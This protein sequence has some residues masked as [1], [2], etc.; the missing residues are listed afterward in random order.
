MQDRTLAACYGFNMHYRF[1]SPLGPIAY[2]WNGRFCSG[3]SLGD[4]AA[5]ADAG[6]DPVSRWL[7]VYFT[8]QAAPLP[9]LAPPATP[10]QLKMRAGLLAIPFGE[11]CTY[12][13]LAARLGTAP[14]A[15]GQA[16]GANPLP[17]LIPCHRVLAV[18]GPGGFASGLEWKERLIGFEHDFS[19]HP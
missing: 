13:Q 16:L 18:N 14:R 3:L 6:N 9:L 17:I 7:V 8:G 2:D 19:T 1:N 15:L 10:F 5:A 12:G 4:E 11:V